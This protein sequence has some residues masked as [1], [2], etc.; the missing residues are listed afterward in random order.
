LFEAIE[1]VE[2]DPLNFGKVDAECLLRRDLGERL[3][4]AFA[5]ILRDRVEVSASHQHVLSTRFDRGCRD[6]PT[7]W[8]HVLRRYTKLVEGRHAALE[9]VAQLDIDIADLSCSAGHFV[10]LEQHAHVFF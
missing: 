3:F 7:S 5:E 8:S 10:N 1:E 6:S 9:P 4:E 2:D